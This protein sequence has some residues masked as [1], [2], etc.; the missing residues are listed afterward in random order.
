MISLTVYELFQKLFGSCL[1]KSQDFQPN[2]IVSEEIYKEEIEIMVVRWIEEG[3]VVSRVNHQ[4]ETWIVFK[5]LKFLQ[6]IQ[7]KLKTSTENL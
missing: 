2:W 4:K 1:N 5:Q 6:R 7:D 3:L